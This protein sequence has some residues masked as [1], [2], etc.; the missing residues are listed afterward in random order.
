MA[1]NTSP[2]ILG[3]ASNLLGFCLLVITSLHMTNQ[4]Q[5]SHVD[6]FTSIIA[7]LLVLSSCF[8]FFSMRSES[9]F[10]KK[11]LEVL[12]DYL[13]MGSLA[14]ILLIIFFLAINYIR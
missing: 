13:F 9:P 7:F 1:Q 2:H 4:A 10:K 3:T 5:S 8:S 14:G 12:A 6:E 11:K